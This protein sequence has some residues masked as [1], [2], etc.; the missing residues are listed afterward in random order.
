MKKG[1][2]GVTVEANRRFRIDFTELQRRLGLWSI[3]CFL[4]GFSIVKDDIFIF[5][6]IHWSQRSLRQSNSNRFDQLFVLNF[7]F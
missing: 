4:F 3:V 1:G 5:F 7:Y 6:S 2:S